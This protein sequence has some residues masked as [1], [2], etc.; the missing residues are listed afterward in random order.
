M[1]IY[2][3]KCK[4]ASEAGKVDPVASNY[5]GECIFHIANKYSTKGKFF[6]YTNLWKEEMIYDGIENCIKYGL[7]NYNPQKYSNPFAYFTEIIH[8]SFIRRIKREK[9]EQYKKLK[10]Q[11]D[12]NLLVTLSSNKYKNNE[13]ETADHLIKDFEDKLSEEKNKRNIK[14]GIDLFVE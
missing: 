5:I 7:K 11:L 10:I 13:N 14:K 4:E 3:Q 9:R 12:N 2:Q 8:W 6:G 1:L